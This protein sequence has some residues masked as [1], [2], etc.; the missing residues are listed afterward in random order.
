M[1]ASPG[2]LH[3]LVLLNKVPGLGPVRLK[4]LRAR[5]GSLEAASRAPVPALLEVP[6]VGDGIARALEETRAS[7]DPEEEL[8]RARELGVSL[9]TPGDPDYPPLLAEIADPPALLYAKGTPSWSARPFVAVVGTRRCTLYGR[10]QAERLAAGLAAAG[11][12]VASGLAR[13]VD[14]A[15]HGAALGAGGWSAAVLGCGLDGCYPPE[16]A[17]L[18]EA[19]SGRGAVCSEFAFGTP[20]LRS[21][22]PRRNRVI[23]GMSLGV[24]VV[25]AARDSGSLITARFAA[26]QNREVFAVPGKI[27]SVR[28][29]GVNS[30]IKEGAKLVEGVEDILEEIAG[31]L[32]ALPAPA[33]APAAGGAAA[34]APGLEGK[35]AAVLGAL[36]AEPLGIEEVIERSGLPAGE[37]AGVLFVLEMKGLARQFPGKRFARRSSGAGT[38]GPSS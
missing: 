19:L 2:E 21:N 27:D 26:D 5:F 24:V 4:A 3:A 14:T 7:F 16:N 28:S 35:P 6:G 18:K 30:L 25:E 8:R 34:P 9:L 23:S 32:P 36:G 38:G 37:V 1:P 13:G 31:R 10:L 33:P 22:F 17:K 11:I 15:A 29:S 12:G 20:P